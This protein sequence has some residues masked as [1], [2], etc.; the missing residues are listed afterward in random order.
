M[1]SLTSIIR[2]GRAVARRWFPELFVRV[3]AA[4]L[5]RAETEMRALT[6]EEVREG[7]ESVRAAIWEAKRRSGGR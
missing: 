2:K 7:K 1:P 6:Q 4:D 5:E 3:T